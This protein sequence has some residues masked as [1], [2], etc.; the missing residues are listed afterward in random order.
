M[1]KKLNNILDEANLS[2]A[3]KACLMKIFSKAKDGQIEEFL[4]LVKDDFDLLKDLAGIYRQKEEA[5][6]KKDK[7]LWE[8]VMGEELNLI[9]KLEKNL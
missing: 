1:I 8:R 3:D 5:L 4:D 2:E 7:K 9:K 6:A